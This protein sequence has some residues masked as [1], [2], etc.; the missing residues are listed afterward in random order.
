[1]V[2]DSSSDGRASYARHSAVVS[3][4]LSL[5]S[6]HAMKTHH[7]SRLW[8][9]TTA[10]AATLCLAATLACFVVVAVGGA[11]PS[12]KRESSIVAPRTGD[13][14]QVGDMHTV[15]WYVLH[16]STSPFEVQNHL[17]CRTLTHVRTT[18]SSGDPIMAKFIL[19]YSGGSQN[20]HVLIA[21]ECIVA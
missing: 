12:Y 10:A 6:T 14:W 1:M 8:R 18:N 4:T 5:S 16:F 19:A 9:I 21:G 2:E 15:Q 17:R 13:V 11:F 3:R 20:A 7:R